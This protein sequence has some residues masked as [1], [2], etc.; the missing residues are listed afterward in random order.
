MTAGYL[1]SMCE[2]G[3]HCK[4]NSRQVCLCSCDSDEEPP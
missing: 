3:I 4:G 2:I 1:C